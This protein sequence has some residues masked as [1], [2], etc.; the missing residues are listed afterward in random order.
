MHNLAYMEFHV[1]LSGKGWVM[2]SFSRLSVLYVYKPAGECKIY[3]AWYSRQLYSYL[4]LISWVQADYA[5]PL[6]G[7]FW[8]YIYTFMVWVSII[9]R[10]SRWHAQ[11]SISWCI[12]SHLK[13][14][15]TVVGIS[16]ASDGFP[17]ISILMFFAGHNAHGSW[18]FAI[19][20]LWIMIAIFSTYL[21]Y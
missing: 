20:Y 2:F 3:T 21:V 18:W 14:E 17:Q 10:R 11:D 9:N 6:W 5:S 4:L 7:L 8:I 13:I 12:A 19:Y 1:W 15:P 16:C